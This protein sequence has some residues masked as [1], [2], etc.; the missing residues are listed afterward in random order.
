[1]IFPAIGMIRKAFV[2]SL[3]EGAEQEYERR[4]NPIWRE[5]TEIL[6]QHGVSNY[7][8]FLHPETRQLFAYAEVEDEA[9]WNAIAETDVCRRWWDHMRDLM[10]S[11]ADGS[12]CATDLRRVFSLDESS[13]GSTPAS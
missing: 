12:P 9:R 3:H 6:L 7:H 1:M 4:H 5:L 11:H 8:I 10:P 13:A 2:M